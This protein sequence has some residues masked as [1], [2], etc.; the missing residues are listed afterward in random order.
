MESSAYAGM[1]AMAANVLLCWVASI[2]ML[3]CF[4]M[5][6][7]QS[8]SR[9]ESCEIL[10]NSWLLPRTTY[11]QMPSEM[12]RTLRHRELCRWSLVIR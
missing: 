8:S 5:D 4:A 10:A 11:S 2:P 7:V 6:R 9:H 1:G 12:S 3:T